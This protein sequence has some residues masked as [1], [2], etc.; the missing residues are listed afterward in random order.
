MVTVG[1]AIGATIPTTFGQTKCNILIDTGAMK[2]CMSQAYYQQLML[3]ATRTLHSCNIKSANGTNLCPIGVT[4]C[5]FKIGMKEYKNDFIVCKNLV[6]P[7]ILG[8]DFLRKHSIW[9]GWS[10]TGKV[11]L[12]SQQKFLVESLEVLMKGPIIHNRQ[13]INIPGRNLAVISVLLDVKALQENQVYEVKP[14]LLLTNEHP[15]LVVL[16]MLHLVQKEKYNSIP[17]ALVNLNDDE[18]IFLRK[19]EI[20]GCLEPTPIEMNEIVQE[21]CDGIGEGEEKEDES[22]PLEKKFITS[23]AEVNTHRKMQLQ[24]AEVTGENKEEFRLLCE[25]FEDIF[26]KSSSDIGKT[27]LITMDIDTGDS[28]PVCQRPYNLPLKHQEWV[29]KELETLEKAGM[30]VRSISPWASPIVVVPK[31]TE[32]GEP[33]RRRLCVDYRVINSLLPEVQKAHSKA[34]GILTLVPLPQI[35]HIYARLRGSQIF[36]TFDLRSGYHHMELSAEARA[37]SAFITPLDKFEFTRSPFGLSQAPAYFQRLMNQVIK[38]LPFA[39]VYLDDVLIHSPDIETHL[40]HIRILFQR[41]RKADLKLKDSKCN[42]FKTHVQYLGHLVS[43]KGI[44]PL[45]EKLESVK[46]M[47][48]PTTP[49]EIK[50]FLGL[51]GYYRKFIPRF[52]DIARPMT[53]LTRQ[54]TPF[55]WTIQCQALFEMLKDALITSPILKYPDPNKPYTLF[56]DTS[57]HAWACMLTQEYEHEKDGKTYKINHPITFASGLF[58]GSQLNW[59][60]LKEAFAIYSSIKKLSYYLEDADIVL[61]SDHLPL[62]KFLHKNTLNTKVNNWA[63]EISPYRIQ[64]EYIKGIKNTLADTM[65][66]LIQMDPEAKLNP[67]PE[68]YEFGYHAFEDLE[69]IKSDIQ[70]IKISTEEE[71][72]NLP[73]EEIKL[74]LSDEK[75]LALQAEDK[76]CSEINSK[77]QKGQLQDRNPYYKENEVLKR[78][79]ED[80]KQRF[81]VVVLPQVLSGAALQLAHE[82]LGHN[83]SPRTY[84][85]LKRNYFWKGLKPMVKRHVQ[86]CRFCQEHNK[87]SVKYSKYNFEAEPAPMKFISMDLIGEFHPPSSKGNRYALTVICMFTGY[88][89]CIPLPDKK[90]E[91]VLRAYMNHVYCKH[92]GSLKILSDNGTEFKNKLME[93]VSKEL[94]VEYKVY[95]PPYRPQS[96]GRIESFHYFLKACIAKHITTQL[97]WDDVVP[98]ACAA[99]NFFPN[100]HSRE[101]PFFLMFRRDPLIPLTK[102]LRPKLRYLG[103]NE[104][105]LSLET[106]QNIYQLVVTNLKMAREKRQPSSL[107]DSKLKEGDLVLIKDH[108]AKAFKPRFKGSFHVIKQKGNQVEI[109]LTEGGETTKVHV[110]DVKKVTPA[111]HVVTQLPDYN[112]LGRL[113]KLRLNPKSIPD[114]DW[115]LASELHPNLSLYQTAKINDSVTATTQAT[116]TITAEIISKPIKLKQD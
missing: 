6:R 85:L 10:P 5:E 100:E 114:L 19:G 84:A 18:R 48:A 86:S 79:V 22:I 58:K 91:T 115:Q 68:G 13:G 31:K 42:Y 78:Y 39:F 40:Q 41:L 33:P 2:S 36:S 102:L 77:L 27:P 64:F 75:L 101:S 74:P 24:D 65:S 113:T 94:G 73:Q 89:F 105:I 97:E 70:E 71:P 16:P 87:Q 21:K 29:Q 83:G 1:S 34:K 80:G 67:E 69:P 35:D 76:F 104:S 8:T 23:P 43:G 32:P 7:C 3:P 59:A 92:G 17:V 44:K 54:D 14:N 51:V 93:E 49:K 25:E 98:L 103:N 15:N 57:K 56:T 47:P 82:G 38:G 45:P 46:K 96:N 99:Y 111:E 63:I 20:L 107:V 116:T 108:T 81:E 106:L 37:K 112:K 110:T 28:P 66:R 60:A 90:A 53:N 12:V 72:I 11:Q 30:I 95:S 50:Q 52:A 88:A 61:R 4:E 62:K 9:T 55:E 26:S 109:R